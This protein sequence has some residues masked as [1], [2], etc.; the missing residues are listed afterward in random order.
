MAQVAGTG[1][2][3]MS[4]RSY[5]VLRDRLIMLEIA[6]GDPINEAGLAAELGV[7]RTPVREALKHLG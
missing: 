2:L 6:P 5:E 7:G 3:S 1:D 4:Q